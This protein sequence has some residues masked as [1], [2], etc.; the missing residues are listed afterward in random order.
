MKR[1]MSSKSSLFLLE[2]MISILFFSIA[3]AVCVQ[4]FVKAHLVSRDAVNL[5]MAA[6][7]A[8]SAA[9][10]LAQ[11]DGR[12]ELL[13]EFPE[14]GETGEGN[15]CVYYDEG[16]F[17]CGEQDAVF[18]MEIA[19]SKKERM[20]YGDIRVMDEQGEEIY[21]LSVRNYIPYLAGEKVAGHE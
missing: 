11:G 10:L 4:V 13:Q 19:L 7:A 3:A 17:L 15:I 8:S 9:E 20:E 5:N 14:A 6:S 18:F 21:L 1:K 2:M 16:W 12:E